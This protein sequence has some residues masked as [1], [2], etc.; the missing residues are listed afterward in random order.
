[1]ARVLLREKGGEEAAARL[2]KLLDST[3]GERW[4]M[5]ATAYART[6]DAK[7]V[8]YFNRMKILEKNEARRRLA[9]TLHNLAS[10]S[11]AAREREAAGG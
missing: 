10:A 1:M 2:A 6:G 4:E 3:Q 5:V 8:R 9:R 7:A 11:K